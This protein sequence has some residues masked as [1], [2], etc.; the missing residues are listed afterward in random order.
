MDSIDLK[1]ISCLRLWT[2]S[3]FQMKVN[4]FCISL[5][6][7]FVCA[8]EHDDNHDDDNGLELP[9]NTDDIDDSLDNEYRQESDSESDREVDEAEEFN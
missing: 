6:S 8:D 9:K 1:V 3:S 5:I 2:K 7:L 4:I